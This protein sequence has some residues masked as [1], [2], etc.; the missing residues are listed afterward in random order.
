MK[1]IVVLYLGFVWSL[2]GDFLGDFFCDL[3][4]ISLR[5]LK[6]LQVDLAHI[7]FNVRNVGKRTVGARNNVN[8]RISMGFYIR[9]H[10]PFYFKLQ[11]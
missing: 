7:A 6:T 2:E 4:L 3:H 1:K 11:L 8:T 9:S 10:D 5:G